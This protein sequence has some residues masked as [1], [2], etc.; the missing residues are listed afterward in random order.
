MKKFTRNF[1]ENEAEPKC[2]DDVPFN[3]R[4]GPKGLVCANLLA[5]VNIVVD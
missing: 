1:R 5:R 4:P 3:Y 2:G